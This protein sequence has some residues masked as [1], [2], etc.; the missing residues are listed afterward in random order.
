MSSKSASHCL[1]ALMAVVHGGRKGYLVYV[2]AQVFG[3]VTNGM[4]NA[5]N[6]AGEQE[7]LIRRFFCNAEAEKN[8]CFLAY[9]CSI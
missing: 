4:A 3:D 8:L 6:M 2:A 9:I 7:C 1:T 5:A